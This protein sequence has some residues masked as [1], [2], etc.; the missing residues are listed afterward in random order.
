MTP[1]RKFFVNGVRLANLE[2][3]KFTPPDFLSVQR[4]SFEKFILQEY[5][6]NPESRPDTGLES[7][8]REVFPIEDIHGR[9][10]IEYLYYYLDEPKYTPAQV[11]DKELTYSASLYGRFRLIEY[12]EPEEVEFAEEIEDFEPIREVKQ[13]IEQD[14]FL[15]GFPLMTERGDFI[16]NGVERVIISQLHRAPGVYFEEEEVDEVRSKYN[17]QIIP[18]RG[19][20]LKFNIKLTEAIKVNLNGRRNFPITVLIK[21]LGYLEDIKKLEEE[22]EKLVEFLREKEYNK[23]HIDR[24]KEIDAELEKVEGKW[25]SSEYILPLFFEIKK[26]QVDKKAIGGIL[27]KDIVADK[28]G[29]VILQAGDK[30]EEEGIK[31]IKEVG[32]KKVHVVSGVEKKSVDYILNAFRKDKTE[33][34]REAIL[35]IYRYLR[36]TDAPNLRIAKDYFISS[37]F[38]L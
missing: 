12:E 32:C 38:D 31:K 30:I 34:G 35:E 22:R 13:S 33:N 4:D 15:A 18:D 21:A 8:F 36:G 5:N 28:T 16:I 26:I 29:E 25:N 6:D 1:K 2:D 27:A 10:K 7:V 17:A 19:S 11:K 14:V 23:K 37:F 20:W 3:V 9:Y 24:I